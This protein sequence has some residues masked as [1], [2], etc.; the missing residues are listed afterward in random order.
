MSSSAA[1]MAGFDPEFTNLD[2]YIRVITRRIWDERR[3]DDIHRYYSD[4]C[5]VEMPAS[6]TSSIQTVVDGTIASLGVFPDRRP[7]YED[8][9]QSGDAETGFL[10]SHRG[11]SAMTHLGDG[12]FGP[13][14]GR[15]VHARAIA[16]CV[17]KDNRIVH[18]W[19]IRDQAAI[20][21]H[22]GLQPRDL[23]QRWLNER[24]AWSKPLAGPAPSWYV[25]A[26]SDERRAQDYAALLTDFAR[27]RGD[28]ALVY[29]DAVHHIGPG[30]ATRYGHQEVAGYWSDLF[31]ALVPE[32]FD[33]EH[34]ALQR[35][36]GRADRIAL[37]WRAQATHRGNGMFGV[38]TGRP[39]EI[40]GINHVELHNGKVV[41]EWVLVDDVALWM[42]VL[43]PAALRSNAS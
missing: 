23:A 1:G 42:Q 33:I 41:R 43:T 32:R 7:L 38:A 10:S 9:I 15:R 37:R 24:G 11:I 8:V 3:F 14:S 17:C 20:A 34:L 26:I 35:G 27:R 19:L 36:G 29:D 25:S 5:I 6:V 13:A 22:I 12:V 2:E 16:D 30:G 40:M 18:E 31:G 4:P 39:V 21:L 28:P